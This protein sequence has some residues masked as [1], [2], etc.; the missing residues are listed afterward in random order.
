MLNL[1]QIVLLL[2][3]ILLVQ[4]KEDDLALGNVSTKDSDVLERLRSFLF[5]KGISSPD[6]SSFD[7]WH[8]FSGLCFDFGSRKSRDGLLSFI[9]K[10]KIP[11]PKI[12]V[13]NVIN[14]MV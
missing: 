4:E 8:V 3:T 12:K 5:L 10:S 13:S 2:T 9:P 14:T 1:I 11:G 6:D 7:P